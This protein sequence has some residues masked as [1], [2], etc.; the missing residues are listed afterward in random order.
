[1]RSASHRF[2]RGPERLRWPSEGLPCADSLRLGFASGRRCAHALRASHG[3]SLALRQPDHS[4]RGSSGHGNAGDGCRLPVPPPFAA[5]VLRE[6]ASSRGLTAR[7]RSRHAALYV[8]GKRPAG[9]LLRAPRLQTTLRF[10]AVFLFSLFGGA[11]A[12]CRWRQVAPFGAS[13]KAPYATRPAVM[14]RA[15]HTPAQAMPAGFPHGAKHNGYY[16]TLPLR[17]AV[18]AGSWRKGLPRPPWPSQSAGFS[19]CGSSAPALVCR[20]PDRCNKLTVWMSPLN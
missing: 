6:T 12:S 7:A 15:G 2:P 10:A 5:S 20:L 16:V 11:A 19:P 14:L 4:G 17:S 3:C 8:N 1:M 13:H 18:A 9:Q